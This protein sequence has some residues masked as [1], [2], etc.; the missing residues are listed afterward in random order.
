M[1]RGIHDINRSF[2]FKSNPGFIFHDSPGFE[3]GDEKQLQDVMSLLEEKAKSAE[4]DD[5]LHAIWS[6]SVCQL[7]YR[8]LMIDSA[9]KVLFCSEQCSATTPTRNEVF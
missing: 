9:V 1:Q 7:I 2:A 5:Q 8:L 6:V 4:V 3:A